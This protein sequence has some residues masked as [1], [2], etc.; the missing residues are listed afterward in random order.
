MSTLRQDFRRGWMMLFSSTV[1]RGC[2]DYLL[3]ERF[4]SLPR[5]NGGHKSTGLGLNFVQEKAAWKC[6]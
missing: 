2:P 6:G 5:P 3:T 1:G 4:Y